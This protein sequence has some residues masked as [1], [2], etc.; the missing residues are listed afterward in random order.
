MRP[1]WNCDSH[2]IRVNLTKILFIVEELMTRTHPQNT[3]SQSQNHSV[4]LLLATVVQNHMYY[5]FNGIGRK[6]NSVGLLQ[7]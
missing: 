4:G 3:C 5:N 2:H 7:M 6:V 1:L